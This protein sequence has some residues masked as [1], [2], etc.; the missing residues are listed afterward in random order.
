M[1]FRVEGLEF[2]VCGLGFGANSQH[3]IIYEVIL[4]YT[5]THD[6]LQHTIILI[7]SGFPGKSV[8]SVGTSFCIFR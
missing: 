7:Y 4:R 5:T 2:R 8:G 1:G 6:I 3:A